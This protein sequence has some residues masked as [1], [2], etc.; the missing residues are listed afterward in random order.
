MGHANQS[1][2]AAV[3]A[4]WRL[5][6][7]E[8]MRNHAQDCIRLSRLHGAR[9]I[10]IDRNPLFAQL[11]VPQPIRP[12]LAHPAHATTQRPE[13]KSRHVQDDACTLEQVFHECF[14]TRV[15]K[16]GHGEWIFRAQ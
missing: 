9:R 7:R 14:M 11:G 2:S 6:M 15:Y 10:E 4:W 5:M 1:E 3:H 16:V 8:F 13:F 12:E